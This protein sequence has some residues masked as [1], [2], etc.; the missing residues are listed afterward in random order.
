[1]IHN[2]SR[3][4]A[5]NDD[6]D[7]S[8]FKQDDLYRKILERPNGE[9]LGDLMNIAKHDKKKKKRLQ[10]SLN[11]G[12]R[13]ETVP[14][15][16]NIEI[17]EKMKQ[18]EK[19]EQFVFTHVYDSTKARSF[20]ALVTK[21]GKMKPTVESEEHLEKVIK[22]NKMALYESLT[23]NETLELPEGSGASNSIRFGQEIS[24]RRSKQPT[25]TMKLADR[26][27][28]AKL[29][30]AILAKFEKK[31]YWKAKDLNKDLRQK[32]GFLKEV[33]KEVADYENSGEHHGCYRIKAQ[34][35]LAKFNKTT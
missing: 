4:N 15:A 29:R 30:G 11:E 5:T 33:L 9:Y 23:K 31:E 3:R 35:R 34:Y 21:K 16:Y 14:D 32:D 13:S 28:R 8:T 2:F 7:A 22:R 27:S 25:E 17:E 6:D 24:T 20:E 18:K 19:V 10:F 12:I 1:M 26:M